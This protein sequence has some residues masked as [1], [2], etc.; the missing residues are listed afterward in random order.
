MD[1]NQASAGPG[2][3]RLHIAHRRSP[4][5]LTPLMMEQLAIQQQIELLQ[6]QQQ[7]IAAT[8]QQY[9]NMGMMQPQQQLQQGFSLPQ[10]QMH[11]N[12]TPMN[13]FQYPQQFQNP[14]LGLSLSQPSQMNANAN[15][16]RRNQSALPTMN[17]G[18]PPAPSSGAGGFGDFSQSRENVNSRTSRGGAPAGAGH[19][20]R[21]SLALPEA[22]AKAELAEQ[23]RKTSGFQ[24]PIPGGTG[25]SSTS[26]RTDSPSNAE[27]QGGLA[28]RSAQRGAAHGRSQ[29]MAVPGMG[30][31]TSSQTRGGPG[32]QFP[33]SSSTNDS[34]FD[35]QRRENQGHARTGSRNFEGNWRQQQQQAPP[36]PVYQEQ[37]NSAMGNFQMSQPQNPSGIQPS[38]RARGSVGQSINSIGGFQYN[39]QPQLV[40]L[41]QG[42]MLMQQPQMFSGQGLTPIQVAQLQALQTAQLSGQGVP[43]LQASPIRKL[44]FEQFAATTATAQDTLHSLPASS[45]SPCTA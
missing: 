33:S 44:G 40:Q 38:H 35:T 6:Q 19:N 16:H 31:G 9:V 23:Q 36:Q 1:H 22:K 43:G 7:Q 20:R 25:T 41:P 14:A 27:S 4:S 5:E 10:N 11:G 21:H 34:T 37:Q 15:A 28:P 3:R 24:F 8:Q 29:S 42:A 2:D 18:P 12:V 39:P 26:P 45:Y 13:A 30:R 32:F 17:M